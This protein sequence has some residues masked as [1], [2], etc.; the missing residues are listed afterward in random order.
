MSSS[1]IPDQGALSVLYLVLTLMFYSCFGETE[2]S[3]KSPTII[4][5]KNSTIP[6]QGACNQK[7]TCKAR[8]FYSD[9]HVIYWLSNNNFIEDE[10]PD[11]RV[12]ELPDT[13]HH[14]SFIAEKSLVFSHM[15]QEDYSRTFTCVIQDPSGVDFRDFTLMQTESGNRTNMHCRTHLGRQNVQLDQD[16]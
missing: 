1:L 2:V 13:P 7:V 11:G 9:F 5:P 8:T 16:V 10:H 3:R 15:M 14:A 6:V 4:F 12:M